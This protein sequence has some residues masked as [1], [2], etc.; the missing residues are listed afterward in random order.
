M[1]IYCYQFKKGGTS[2]LLDIKAILNFQ[3]VIGSYLTK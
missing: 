1:T 3:Q 2:W